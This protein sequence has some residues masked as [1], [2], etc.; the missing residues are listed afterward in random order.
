MKPWI[1][2]LVAGLIAYGSL[3]PFDFTIPA[4]HGQAWSRLF[5]DWSLLFSRM[6]ALGNLLLFIPFGF[7]GFLGVATRSNTVAR[8]TLVVFW[9]CVLAL[10]LQMAQIYVPQRT[11]TLSDVLW[12]MVGLCAGIFAA[13]HLS[14]SLVRLPANTLLP[15]AV[16]SLWL[17][18]ELLPF[19]PSLDVQSVKDNLKGL[20]DLPW[21]TD[22]FLFHAAGV[23]LAGCASTAVAGVARG[24]LGLLLLVGMVVVGKVFVVSQTLSIAVLTGF[25]IGYVGW[26]GISRWREPGRATMVLVML[27]C[28]YVYGALSPFDFRGQA[29]P[30][31]WLPFAGLLRGSMLANIQGIA[32]NLCLYAGMLWVIGALGGSLTAGS[33]LLAC[34]VLMFEGIQIFAVGRTAEITEPLLV[35]LLGPLLR[36]VPSAAAAPAAAQ[37]RPTSQR[38]APP[39]RHRAQPIAREGRRETRH[40]IPRTLGGGA[41]ASDFSWKRW[42]LTLGAT[43]FAMAL[44]FYM[45][46]RL[47]RIP[48]NVVELFLWDGAFPFLVIFALSLLWIGASANLLSHFVA[49]SSRPWLAL[50]LLA[51][52]ASLVSLL[53]MYASVTDESIGD[54][55]GSNNVHWHVVNQDMWGVWARNVFMH[56][57]AGVVACFERP[58]RYGALLGPLVTFLGLMLLAVKVQRSRHYRVRGMVLFL[59]FAFLWLWLCKG[60][61]FD[62]ASTDN[63]NELVARDGPTGW[64]GGGYLYLLLAVICANAVLLTYFRATWISAIIAL[65]VTAAAVPLGWWLLN[66]GLEPYVVKYSQTFSGAQFLLGPDRKNLLSSEML[67]MRWSA[68][69]VAGVLV[70]AA[71]ARLVQP[72][73]G[74]LSARSSLPVRRSPRVN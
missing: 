56:I 2:Y 31:G 25:A 59:I 44:V 17:A 10:V 53:L 72:V 22:Q 6:D 18:A 23:M 65:L 39:T 57:P 16:I 8:I 15:I 69:Q 20:R 55:S 49:T 45:V 50:P 12:N 11:P 47:P 9:G 40:E 29:E 58:I 41:V 60:I 54:I 38:T 19:V 74:W 71:G 30:F 27:F 4:A 14:W 34:V 70:L 13:L 51:F 26:C 64:G 1:L 68:V 52:G 66:E 32:A 33:I 37:T 36:A 46:L 63:L 3:Y 24:T 5:G 28:A 62:W 73:I 48:Y 21:A 42:S 61:A 43:C 7:V 35:L 67:F